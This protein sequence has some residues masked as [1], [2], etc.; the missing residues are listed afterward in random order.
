MNIIDA[1][2]KFI[3]P[4]IIGFEKEL[5]FLCLRNEELSR[6]VSNLEAQLL[7]LKERVLRLELK[8]EGLEERIAAK[9]ILTLAEHHKQ[10]PN[11]DE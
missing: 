4:E 6:I 9:L 5:K 2:R 10:L 7:D 3:L 11:K 1:I 8:H